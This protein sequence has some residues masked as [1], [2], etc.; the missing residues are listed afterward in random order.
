MPVKIPELRSSARGQT[1]IITLQLPKV[2]S[3]LDA[4]SR[5]GE[6]LRARSCPSENRR[7]VGFSHLIST[8]SDSVFMQKVAFVLYRLE[9][10]IYFKRLVRACAGT[11][12]VT[13]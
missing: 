8:R 4:V 7:I 2:T 10:T 11:M 1:Q 6:D 12:D 13:S 9:M 3:N 5:E